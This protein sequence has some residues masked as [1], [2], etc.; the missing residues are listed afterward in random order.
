MRALL[1]ALAGL[2]IASSLGW[3]FS[4]TVLVGDWSLLP[5]Y[6]TL[7]GQ[8]RVAFVHLGALIAAPMGGLFG[9]L[10]AI[11]RRSATPRDQELS[12]GRSNPALELLRPQ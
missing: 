1:F 6:L 3:L 10:I 9:F 11:S 7:D 5:R 8:E 2:L 4:F 12:E